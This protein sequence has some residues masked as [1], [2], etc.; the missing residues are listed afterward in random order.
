MAT[1]DW[2]RCRNYRSRTNADG[3]TEWSPGK[4]EAGADWGERVRVVLR[5]VLRRPIKDNRDEATRKKN[6]SPMPRLKVCQRD[7]T[8]PARYLLRHGGKLSACPVVD[9]KADS[10]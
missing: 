6:K 3:L 5:G 10:W 9:K 1:P 8:G 2:K 7:R 4:V